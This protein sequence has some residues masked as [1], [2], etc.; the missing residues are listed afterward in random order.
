MASPCGSL[1]RQKMLS[2][3]CA[4]S[5]SLRTIA[6][7]RVERPVVENGIWTGRNLASW[8]ARFSVGAGCEVQ[9]GGATV[10]ALRVDGSR[11][12]ATAAIDTPA[13][14]TT[15]REVFVIAER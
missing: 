10:V 6:T 4:A 7:S 8:A 9:L 1:C 2:R 11:G 13:A 5:T 15:K 14:A 12:A 3:S